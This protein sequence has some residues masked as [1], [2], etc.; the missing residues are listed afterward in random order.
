VWKWWPW[1]PQSSKI[2]DHDDARFSSSVRPW[3]QQKERKEIL[4]V[5][6]EEHLP[7]Y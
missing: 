5:A 1:G 4:F 3:Q 6:V 7:F 2:N